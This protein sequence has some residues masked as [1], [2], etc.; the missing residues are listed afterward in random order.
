MISADADVLLH[1]LKALEP[2]PNRRKVT[3]QRNPLDR[4]A[5]CGAEAVHTEYRS[6]S[7]IG[8]CAD[9]K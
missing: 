2:N 1:V 6:G 3:S 8:L 4:C 7:E 5:E 9:C